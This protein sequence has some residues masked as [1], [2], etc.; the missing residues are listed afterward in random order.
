MSI[1]DKALPKSKQK[2]VELE[3]SWFEKYHFYLQFA[4][5]VVA[6]FVANQIAIHI[7]RSMTGH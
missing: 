4:F 6:L 7:W 2:L 1:L 5:N 3:T